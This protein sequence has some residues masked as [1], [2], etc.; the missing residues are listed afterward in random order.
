MK[1][2]LVAVVVLAMVGFASM[3]LAADIS[4]GGTVQLRSRDF[5]NMTFDKDQNSK[6]V[7]DTQERVQL[8]VNVKAGDNVK[9]KIALWN[10]FDTWGRLEANQGNQGANSVVTTC[11]VTTGS[12]TATS[13]AKSNA[14]TIG[15]REAWINFN[16]PDLPI[17]V[18]GG[19]QLL[20]LGN[21]GFFRSMHYG[22]DAW[23]VAN[24]TGANTAALVDIK[25]SEAS[26]SSHDA[27]AIALLDVY[28][29]SDNA[30]VGVD[31]TSVLLRASDTEIDNFGI[32]FTGKAGAVAMKAEIDMQSGKDKPN[33]K[34]YSGNEV[35]VKGNLPMDG[36]TINF[37]VAQGS[38]KKSTDTDNKQF[39]TFLDIDPHYT[40]MY[41]YKLPTACGVK[42]SGFCNTTALSVGASMAASKSLT[43]GID[44]YMLTATQKTNVTQTG[45]A[46]GALKSDVGTEIDA[47]INWKLYDNL[48]WNWNLGLFTPGAVYK[49]A[50]G[51]GTDAATGIQ[52]ILALTF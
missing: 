16:L 1:K 8:D 23:V 31:Y 2:V 5:S 27:D 32:N 21:Q 10:D 50:N 34:K 45:A 51:K 46:A 43:V 29:I 40:F 25:V 7:T 44:A 47:T 36:V 19:H 28:K 37:L 35:F 48:T 17:N 30:V 12:C 3:A 11:S 15:L 26:P 42:N 38:G 14:N 20:A 33:D 4:V 18:T 39:V 41:E 52:G 9:G 22:S 13:T 6:N 24:V 49:D